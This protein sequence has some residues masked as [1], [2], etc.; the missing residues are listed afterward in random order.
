MQV[1]PTIQL[2]DMTE[3]QKRAYILADNKLAENAGWDPQ[4]LALELQY[5]TEID[6]DFDIT[7]TGFDTA[8]IDLLIRDATG[9]DDDPAAD[10]L[11]E[12]DRS[13]GDRSTGRFV[14]TRKPSSALWRATEGLR[15]STSGWQVGPDGSPIPIQPRH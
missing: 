3:V 6:I 8:E 1:V 13:T 7:I 11:P 14:A 2:G 4:L 9:R 5:L 10:N 15:L 12:I